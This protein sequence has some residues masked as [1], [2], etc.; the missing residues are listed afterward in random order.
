MGGALG[1]GWSVR[2]LLGRIAWRPFLQKYVL[3]NLEVN[4]SKN[5]RPP[6]RPLPWDDAQGARGALRRREKERKEHDF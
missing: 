4:P 3:S 5:L 6:C 2:S 1:F